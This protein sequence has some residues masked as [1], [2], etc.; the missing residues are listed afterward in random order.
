[1][2][3][4]LKGRRLLL[5]E[6]EYLIAAEQAQTLEELG[7]EVVGPVAT[8]KEALAVAEDDSFR[9]DGAVLDI[10]LHEGRVFPVADALRMRG[11]PFIFT[12]GYDTSAIPDAYAKFPCLQ[13]P[14]DKNLVSRWLLDGLRAGA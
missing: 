5:V 3:S 11:V 2:N 12:T 6:D 1:M 4:I 13:K 10:N 8:V 14:V 9:L 7:I